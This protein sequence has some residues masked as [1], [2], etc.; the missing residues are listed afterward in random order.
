M[1]A[2]IKYPFLVTYSMVWLAW[3]ALDFAKEELEYFDKWLVGK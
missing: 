3:K 1:R 2:M